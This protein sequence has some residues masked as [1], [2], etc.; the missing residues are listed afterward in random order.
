MGKRT[1]QASQEGTTTEEKIG[2]EE[3]VAE[4]RQLVAEI[5]TEAAH[6]RLAGLADRV[7]TQYADKTLDK[8]AKDI[9]VAACTLKR[10]RSVWRAW[11]DFSEP[12]PGSFPFAIAMALQAVKNRAAIV[13]E[14]PTLTRAKAREFAGQQE[15]KKPAAVAS[16]DDKKEPAATAAAAPRGKAVNTKGE[17][18]VRANEATGRAQDFLRW[19]DN[20]P[21]AEIGEVLLGASNEAADAWAEVAKRCSERRRQQEQQEQ[22]PELGDAPSLSPVEPESDSVH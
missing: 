4:A 3:V 8:F 14:Y 22:L 1:H 20:N 10:H 16:G 7:E 6:W 9:G 15:R 18:I 11:K 2:Y 17:A 19:L 12:A 21:D 13:K 5:H